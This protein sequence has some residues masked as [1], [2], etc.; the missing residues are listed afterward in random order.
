[1]PNFVIKRRFSL[2]YFGNMSLSDTDLADAVKFAHSET[3]SNF[4]KG[5][6]FQAKWKANMCSKTKFS[7][8]W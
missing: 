3:S 7:L 6:L 8:L 1:M 4:K 2:A 5:D